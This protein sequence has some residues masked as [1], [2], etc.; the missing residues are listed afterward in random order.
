MVDTIFGFFP[1]IFVEM[2]QRFTIVNENE[3][4]ADVCA[5]LKPQNCRPAFPIYINISTIPK[6]AGN[7]PAD[8]A[9]STVIIIV[10]V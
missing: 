3:G 6:T 1:D 10:Q 8:H 4:S 9:V 5:T 2:E 7:N